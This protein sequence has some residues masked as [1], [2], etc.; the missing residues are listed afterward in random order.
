MKNQEIKQK[1]TK[2]HALCKTDL[3]LELSLKLYLAHGLADDLK[4][5]KTKDI[6][7]AIVDGTLPNLKYYTLNGILDIIITDIDNDLTELS[8][9]IKHYIKFYNHGTN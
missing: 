1:L 7:W 2:A 3:N 6:A 5:D 9:F 4:E 8:I